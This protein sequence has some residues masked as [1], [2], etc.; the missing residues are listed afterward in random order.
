M[1]DYANLISDEIGLYFLVADEE[2][3]EIWG[4]GYADQRAGYLG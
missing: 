1:T 3:K 4:H 2:A